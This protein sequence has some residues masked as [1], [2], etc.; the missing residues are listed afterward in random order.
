MPY[1]ITQ[2]RE[3]GGK[4]AIPYKDKSID[5]SFYY[6]VVVLPMEELKS[7]KKGIKGFYSV[8]KTSIT[9]PS[10]IE[11]R[12]D[13]SVEGDNVRIPYELKG[14]IGFH[15][16]IDPKAAEANDSRFEKN[17]FYNPAKVRLYVRN[18][19]A[20]DS[21]LNYLGL[22]AAFT[23]YIEGELSFDILDD[24]LLPDIATSNRQGFNELDD[25]W[26]LLITILRPLVRDLINRRNTVVEE[27]NDAEQSIKDDRAARAKGNAVTLFRKEAESF[28]IDSTTV[29]ALV[30][31][32]AMLLEGDIDAKAKEKF[33]IFISHAGDDKYFSDFVYEL[34]RKRGAKPEEFFYTSARDE[35]A[36]PKGDDPLGQQIKMNIISDNTLISYFTSSR[37]RNNENCLFEAGAGWA[38]RTIGEYTV[39]STL[40]EDVPDW[41]TNG[42]PEVCLSKKQEIELS[43]RYY[44][45]LVDL[46]NRL[47]EHLN[48]GRDIKREQKIEPFKNAEFPSEKEINDAGKVYRDYMD[49]EIVDHWEYYIRP[50]LNAYFSDE[51]EAGSVEKGVNDK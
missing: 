39:L 28:D 14:W 9:N 35:G 32:Q 15:A 36:K 34:L 12:G 25:R 51:G 47:I 33:V 44:N 21:L 43:V 41:L 48:M 37:F 31:K 11:N 3:H 7:D 19:L 30:A 42:K 50:F 27:R 29:D 13:V 8:P 23:N 24:N 10:L 17:K 49:Q 2:L 20:A 38:T 22:T 40:Y 6:D 5:K 4:V 18:K 46:L 45:Q 26:D 16:T 1:D